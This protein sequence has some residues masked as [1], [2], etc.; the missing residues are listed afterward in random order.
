MHRILASSGI[1]KLATKLYRRQNPMQLDTITRLIDLPGHKVTDVLK[2]TEQSLHLLLKPAG[3]NP[4][5][6]SGCGRLHSGGIHSKE[7][8]VVEDLRISGKRVFLHVPKRKIRCC[9]NGRIRVEEL[10]WIQGRF[11]K[12]FAQ[13][14]YR[15][16]AITTNQEAGWYLEL[17]DE[18][19]YR[20]DRRTLEAL[21]LERLDPVPA[22]ALMSVDE[23]AWQKWHRYVTNVVDIEKRKVIWNHNGRGKAV[24]STFYRTLGS[25]GCQ[26]IK[27]VASDGAKGFLS[28]TKTHAPDALIVLDHFHVKKYLNDA[29]DTVR[30]E[31]LKK[32]RQQ[33]NE[34]AAQILHCNKRFILMQNKVTSR[35]QNLL[36][37]LATLNHRVYQA[38]LLK[39]QFLSVYSAPERK[40]ARRNLKDWIVAAIESELPSFIELGYKFF[41][42]RNYVLNYFLHKITT[43][44]S[45]GINN[46]IKRLSRM[47]YGYKD[48]KYFLLKIHQH[49]GLL[50]PR[51]ST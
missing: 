34:E 6:C 14:V 36:E 46:K 1:V 2:N 17:D 18:T 49:C 23:V 22:P 27:A 45:E 11:T 25:E 15:L 29:V 30:K 37:Q 8:V 32:A 31:E 21:T 39:E 51:L 10:D 42:K 40:T 20:I 5:V 38:M 48:V 16:T 9:E 50:N 13:Q 24:L 19:V 35:K 33:N 26:S 4:P 43:A 7:R 47:A 28:A 44:I 3:Q 41:R 12:R